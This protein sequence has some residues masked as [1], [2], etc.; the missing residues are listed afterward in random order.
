VLYD[1]GIVAQAVG[2]PYV[3]EGTARRRLIV[4]A[5]HEPADIEAV[6]EAFE[7]LTQNTR[8]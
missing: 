6:L 2:T 8:P 5:A 3:P 7:P 4:S 1:R